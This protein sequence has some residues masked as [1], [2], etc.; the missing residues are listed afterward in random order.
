MGERELAV[1]YMLA[2][3]FVQKPGTFWNLGNETDH[4]TWYLDKFFMMSYILPTKISRDR[5][6][7]ETIIVVKDFDH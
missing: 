4:K 3:H 7:L 6:F 1:S 2:Q 5:K